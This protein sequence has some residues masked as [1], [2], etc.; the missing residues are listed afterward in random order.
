MQ[1]GEP[2]MSIHRRIPETCQRLGRRS[3]TGGAT[4]VLDWMTGGVAG[5]RNELGACPSRSAGQTPLRLEIAGHGRQRRYGED[6]RDRGGLTGRTHKTNRWAR[7][8]T[9]RPHVGRYA[10]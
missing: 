10:P 1:A 4:S 8:E 6:V 9:C 5:H 7:Y 3:V 2:D